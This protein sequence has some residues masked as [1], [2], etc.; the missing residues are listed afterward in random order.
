[1]GKR[2]LQTDVLAA[3]SERLDRVFAD[4]PRVCLSFS[5]GKD[6]GV[7]LNLA[8]EAARR[9]GRLPL[10]V[11][12]VDL[13]AQYAHTIAYAERALLRPEIRAHWICLPINLRN[14]VSQLQPSWRC[15]DP[16]AND[17]W[18]RPMPG[19][20]CVI[21]AAKA[22]ELGWD[23]FE[24]GMEFESFVPLFN[25]WFAG[26][27]DSCSLVGIRATESLNRYLAVGRDDI[28]TKPMWQG[29]TWTTKISK[30]CFNG[31]PLYDWQTEDIWTANGR[32]GWDYNRIYDL[33]H[34]A[35][36][37]LKDMRICQ[38]FGDDQ[39]RGLYLFKIL[40]HDTW[41]K[42]VSRV[43]GA[44]YGERYVHDEAMA[45]RGRVP[46][47]DGHTYQSYAEF[48]LDTM[49]PP[50]AAG[51]REKIA[52]FV[53]WWAKNGFPDGIPDKADARQETAKKAPSWRRV[54]KMLVK[55]DMYGKTLSFGLT[56][57]DKQRQYEMLMLAGTV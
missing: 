39:R 54:V 48:L 15:W 3:A 6:S 22:A 41:A 49:P 33:F 37:P 47:P 20:N 1:M 55:N 32:M 13:E 16:Q 8:V 25:R 43:E 2:F 27:Q 24:E 51:Y 14:A 56:K 5:A 9:A 45:D 34:K 19:H 21:D 53:A 36:V 26:G 17:K 46:L 12:F 38:P 11:M 57:K 31:Y 23:W 50:L 28:E 10:D 7:L 44:N 18:V 40:E 42:L 29:L 35:G 52:K 30:N 4:F